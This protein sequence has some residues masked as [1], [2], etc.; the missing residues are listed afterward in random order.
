MNENSPN[1]DSLYLCMTSINR[2]MFL[3]FRLLFEWQRHAEKG[4]GAWASTP[5]FHVAPSTSLHSPEHSDFLPVQGITTVL[6]S[7]AIVS[8]RKYNSASIVEGYYEPSPISYISSQSS[9]L[10]EV[11]LM[12]IISIFFRWWKK[13]NKVHY[14][15]QVIQLVAELGIGTEAFQLQPLHWHCA[16]YLHTQELSVNYKGTHTHTQ[17]S[18]IVVVVVVTSSLH[19]HCLA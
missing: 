18:C 10:Y 4:Y 2:L 1:T 13:G 7:N 14:L 11:G 6:P 19:Q 16:V 17:V 9:K 8:I 15:P 12:I 5:V 3:K